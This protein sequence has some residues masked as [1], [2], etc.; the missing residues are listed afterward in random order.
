MACKP[1]G[2]TSGPT[3][4]KGEDGK[5]IKVLNY[6]RSAAHKSLDPPKQFDS[7]SAELIDNVYDTLLDYH[8]LKRPYALTPNLVEEM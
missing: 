7:A 5:P 4:E 3:I 6:F 1:S 8:Y 2:S